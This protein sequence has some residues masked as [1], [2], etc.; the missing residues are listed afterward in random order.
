MPC[1]LP[2][3]QF[4]NSSRIREVLYKANS[5][6]AS[7]QASYSTVDSV[8]D[9]MQFDNSNIITEMLALKNEEAQLLGYNNHAEVSLATKMADTP[10]QVIQFLRDLGQRA[11]PYA[12]Q[13]LADMRSYAKEHLNMPDPQ[14]WDWK[15]LAGTPR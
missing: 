4:A 10:A 7:D 12:E 9:A 1:Y 11:R 14:A 5:T 2:V 8:K 6:R 13:D 3:M 15:K